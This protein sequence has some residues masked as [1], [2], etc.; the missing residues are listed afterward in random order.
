LAPVVVKGFFP[1][2]KKNKRCEN[3]VYL[4]KITLASSKSN[5]SDVIFVFLYIWEET[6]VE[7]KMSAEQPAV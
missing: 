7:Q 6:S 1:I 5:V 3:G 2:R 4:N